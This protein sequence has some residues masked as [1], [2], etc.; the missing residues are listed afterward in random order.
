MSPWLIM[1]YAMYGQMKNSKSEP[2]IF[3][4]SFGSCETLV[5]RMDAIHPQ[6]HIA[7]K[8]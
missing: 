7:Q 8:R 1:Q 6:I 5:S 4:R 2:P 3:L